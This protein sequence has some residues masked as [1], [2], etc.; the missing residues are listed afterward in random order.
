MI[1]LGQK[2]FKARV[3]VDNIS[4][5]EAQL[6]TTI[7]QLAQRLSDGSLKITDQVAVLTPV[8]R[9][10]GNNVNEKEISELVFGSMV[11]SLKA[12]GEI[13]SNVLS[14]GEDEGNVEKVE[15]Q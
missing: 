5:I 11:D 7:M 4:R 3:T 6:D 12:I 13:V 14:V 15:S 2:N 1:Q 9:A 8:I 10:G